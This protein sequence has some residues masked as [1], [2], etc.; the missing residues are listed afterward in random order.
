MRSWKASGVGCPTH[1]QNVDVSF[2]LSK[3]DRRRPWDGEDK[4]PVVG[5]IATVKFEK[6]LIIRCLHLPGIKNKAS[7]FLGVSRDHVDDLVRPEEHW[8]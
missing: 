5:E 4:M 6:F 8:N 1:Q 2:Q 7:R 3:V